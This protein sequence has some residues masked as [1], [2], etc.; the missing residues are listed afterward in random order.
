MKD[1][2]SE[3]LRIVLKTPTKKRNPRS[4]IGCLQKEL[5]EQDVSKLMETI[6]DRAEVRKIRTKLI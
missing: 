2:V 4:V 6:R 3:G 5:A 1:L